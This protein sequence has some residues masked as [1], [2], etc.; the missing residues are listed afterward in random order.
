MSDNKRN[1]GKSN[2]GKNG[3]KRR[4]YLRNNR[5]ISS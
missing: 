4:S 1:G 3:Q 2:D 5:I